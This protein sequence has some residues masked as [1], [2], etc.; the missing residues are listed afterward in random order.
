[1][2]DK[3]IPDPTRGA[4]AQA[5][6]GA[7]AK[8]GKKGS[9][10]KTPPTVTINVPSDS[11]TK[12]KVSQYESFVSYWKAHGFGK[13]LTPQF[14]NAIQQV[15]LAQNIDPITF[16]SL[17]LNESGGDPNSVNKQSGAIGYGQLLPSSFIGPHAFHNGTLPW[18]STH[19]ITLADLKNP[20]INL[21]L[22]AAY[23]GYLQNNYPADAYGRYNAGP[24]ASPKLTA[25]ITQG[26]YG[27]WTKPWNPSWVPSSQPTSPPGKTGTQVP[28]G[29]AP[30]AQDIPF[31]DPYVA[32][33]NKNNKFVTT[34][35]PNKALQ[36]DGAP[37][38]RSS[39]LTLKTSLSS[40]YISYTGKRPTNHQIQNFLKAGWS[41]YTL[42]V[43]LSKSQAFKTSPIYKQYSANF[44]AALKDLLPKGANV[45]D[46]LLRQAVIN[47]WDATTVAAR[48]RKTPQYLQSNEFKG[49]V[50]SMLNIHQAVMGA[51]DSAS[52]I[53]IRDAALAGW[54]ADQYAAWLRS[55]PGYKTSPEFQ[56][57]ALGF[58]GALGLITGSEPVLQ[59]GM[60]TTQPGVIQPNTQGTLPSDPRVKGT[61]SVPPPSPD[62]LGATLSR[63]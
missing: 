29:T 39:F 37:L 13:V 20:A 61:P 36:Y 40:H 46:E 42:D 57:R 44:S 49:N 9:S 52:M 63:A 33:I 56:T 1:M 7:A 15:A 3:G 17:V 34:L 58:L 25:Q 23:Y 35:D 2:A 8:A 38:T 5:A 62:S 41:T 43:L 51:P 28:G 12:G 4:A 21:R 48:L 54:T 55:Q 14:A 30:Q 50:A 27:K 16:L 53:G 24:N 59:P 45:P 31:K 18:N 6:A 26:F 60:A 11:G 10:G 22:A 47:Q 19:K 32:G